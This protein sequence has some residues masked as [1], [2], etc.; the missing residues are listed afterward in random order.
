M[1]D[2]VTCTV[3]NKEVISLCLRYVDLLSSKIA[4]IKQAFFEL[5]DAPRITGEYLAKLNTHNRDLTY[6]VGQCYDGAAS[7]SSSNVGCQAV[8][9]ETGFL[10][11]LL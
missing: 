3:S 7:M 11:A 2:E 8:V 4:V 10:S 6:C 9:S 1:S 5:A